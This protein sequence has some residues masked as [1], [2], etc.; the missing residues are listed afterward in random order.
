[1]HLCAILKVRT[2]AVPPGTATLMNQT[3]TQGSE[4]KPLLYQAVSDRLAHR[5]SWDGPWFGLS[6]VG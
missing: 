5:L 6:R 3:E 1:M 4:A 2:D